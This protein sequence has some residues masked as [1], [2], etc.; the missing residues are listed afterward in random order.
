MLNFA[1]SAGDESC[2]QVSNRIQ[3]EPD[4][5]GATPFG[6]TIQTFHKIMSQKKP[7]ELWMLYSYYVATSQRQ[8][9]QQIWCTTAFVGKALGWGHEKVKRVKERLRKLG[10]IEDIKAKNSAGKFTKPYIL[11]RYVF[12][13]S[14]FPTGG[15]VRRAEA[16]TTN[17]S[18]PKGNASRE[19]VK[20]SHSSSTQ[21]DAWV[22]K[23]DTQWEAEIINLYHRILC[24]SD[25]GFLPIT[26]LTAELKKAIFMSEDW[27]VPFTE[28]V[29]RNALKRGTSRTLLRILWDNYETEVDFKEELKS[30][31]ETEF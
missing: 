5:S 24:S 25:T 15:E 6:A 1:Y 11:V 18:R 17:A 22:S 27:G 19:R 3:E 31:W 16:K 12:Q 9:T 7:D 14:S 20:Y 23:V 13:W 10:L 2:R 28:H 29:F 4:E 30:D 21:A 8:Q 26:K